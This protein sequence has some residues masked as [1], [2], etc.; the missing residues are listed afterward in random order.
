[1]EAL[2]LRPVI[3]F[4][5]ALTC[6]V[7]IGYVCRGRLSRLSNLRFRLLPILWFAFGLQLLLFFPL[8]VADFRLRFT[9]VIVSYALVAAWIM[10][11]SRGNTVMPIRT[12][13]LMIAIGFTVNL[14]VI[15]SNGGMPVSRAALAEAGSSELPAG[16]IFK[17]VPASST[18]RFT[19]L[20]DV[21]PI[22]P[23]RRVVSAGDVLLLAGITLLVVAGMTTRAG[24]TE[25]AP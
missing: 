14:L 2:I 23:L 21:V 18:T 6:G 9:L 10:F 11:N 13:T 16:G 8:R 3:L 1:M 20:G 15:A 22:R 4:L 5:I 7:V 12:A 19:W 24:D 17:H 25:S